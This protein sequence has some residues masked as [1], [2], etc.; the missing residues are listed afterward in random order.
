MKENGI[1]NRLID[2]YS[3]L[4]VCKGDIERAAEALIACYSG[5]GKLLA[6]GNGGSSADSD[7]IVGEL[8]KGFMSRRPLSSEARKRFAAMY[9]AEGEY[10]AEHLQGALPAISL[11]GSAALTSAFGNDV[12]P[13]MIYAQQVFGYG[14]KGDVLLGI[15][16][17]GNSVNVIRA[18]QTANV[19]GLV[20]IG[21]TGRSGGR[22]AEM[23]DIAIKVPW[24]S[25]PDV[26]ER[27][28]PVYHTLCMAV[29]QHFFGQ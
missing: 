16:T 26:Q 25:T 13:D 4:A 6:C 15:S 28:L 29:E 7:H 20:T 24:D 9:S 21:L 3:E 18:L 8:M 1:V 11:S 5:G 23:C 10:L 12:A 14:R 27:H 17:S 22:M 2:K 19:Q